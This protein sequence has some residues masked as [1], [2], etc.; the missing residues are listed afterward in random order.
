MPRGKKRNAAKLDGVISLWEKGN[1][2]IPLGYEGKTRAAGVAGSP[3]VRKGAE[4][5][6]GTA[7]RQETRLWSGR[8][9][10][11]GKNACRKKKA[12]GGRQSEMMLSSRQKKRGQGRNIAERETTFSGGEN[13]FGL[14][15]TTC[16]LMM[17]RGKL[18]RKDR[19]W[20]RVYEDRMEG[21]RIFAS[22]LAPRQGSPSHKKSAIFLGPQELAA[23]FSKRKP[24]SKERGTTQSWGKGSIRHRIKERS[25]EL[26]RL[27]RNGTETV[28]LKLREKSRQPIEV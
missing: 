23:N 20:S 25:P 7:I 5:G 2:H 1:I 22:D 11:P 24:H 27:L 26:V 28:E 8:V 9:V 14:H 12:M 3:Q 17:G 13:V 19:F 21:G 4:A 18:V 10:R 6:S 15:E 16:T